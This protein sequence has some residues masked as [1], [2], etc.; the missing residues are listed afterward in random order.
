LPD[1]TVSAHHAALLAQGGVFVIVD[2][3]STGGVFVTSGGTRQVSRC[4][5]GDRDTFVCGQTTLQLR[6]AAPGAA[7]PG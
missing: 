6:L 3:G 7:G 1:P 4:Q 2:T 5:I